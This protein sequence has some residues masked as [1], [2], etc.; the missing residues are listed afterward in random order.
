MR[1]SLTRLA[2]GAVVQLTGAL[3]R[4]DIDK[5][6]AEMVRD[7]A[8]TSGVPAFFFHAPMILPDATTR[9]H[10]ASPP[11]SRAPSASTRT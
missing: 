5:S 2:A 6:S 8:R 11:R 10:S 1:T 3:S 7:V 4:P 9:M